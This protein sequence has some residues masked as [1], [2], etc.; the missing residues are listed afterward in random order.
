MALKVI[1]ETNSRLKFVHMKNKLLAIVL[2][3]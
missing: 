1:N 2:R 3:R